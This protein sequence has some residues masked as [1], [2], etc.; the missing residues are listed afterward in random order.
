ME[1]IHLLTVAVAAIAVIIIFVGAAYQ[2][3]SSLRSTD[4]RFAS[5][6][7]A[8]LARVQLSQPPKPKRATLPGDPF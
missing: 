2:H 3:E 8:M 4:L 7:R 5:A 1:I 6:T